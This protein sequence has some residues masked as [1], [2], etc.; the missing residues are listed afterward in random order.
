MRVYGENNDF[1]VWENR[2]LRV[3]LKEY[4]KISIKRV[5][6]IYFILFLKFISFL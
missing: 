3:I 2:Y 1:L 6:K 5:F 4:D